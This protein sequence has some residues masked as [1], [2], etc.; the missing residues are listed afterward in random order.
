MSEEITVKKMFKNIPEGERSLGK[1]R[2]KWLDDVENDLKEMGVS[3]WRRVVRVSRH[4]E[5]DPEGGQGPAWNVQL[6]KKETS[7]VLAWKNEIRTILNGLKFSTT[8][9]RLCVIF[10][11]IPETRR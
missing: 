2:K 8:F 7:V 5:I 1:S 9:T 4:L 3:G 11:R 10:S 6:V